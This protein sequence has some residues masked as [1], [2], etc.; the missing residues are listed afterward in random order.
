[1]KLT[2]INYG[3]R[4]ALVTL[5]TCCLLVSTQAIANGHGKGKGHSHSN[6]N[7]HGKKHGK[8]N[9][10]VK[11]SICHYQS[12]GTYKL[13]KLKTRPAVRHLTNHEL[14]K[15]PVVGPDGK[16][17]CDLVSPPASTCLVNV[18]GTPTTVAEFLASENV[19]DPSF[20]TDAN[21]CAIRRD[22]G[23]SLSVELYNNADNAGVDIFFFEQ[24]G[25]NYRLVIDNQQQYNDCAFDLETA[26][27]AQGSCPEVV[28]PGF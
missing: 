26:T 6:S 24:S 3:L 28:N 10:H 20:Q 5:S 21:S 17:T 18:N 27:N 15:E 1:M 14:D 23:A 16:E 2:T 25:P 19:T 11:M 13:H 22:N 4:V 8:S 7:S 12:D 9:K